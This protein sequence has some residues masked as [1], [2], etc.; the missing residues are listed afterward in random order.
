M[1]KPEIRPSTT[2]IPWGVL[3]HGSIQCRLPI[4]VIW[5]NVTRAMPIKIAHY[6]PLNYKVKILRHWC[7]RDLYLVQ[8]N[9]FDITGSR[10]NIGWD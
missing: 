4:M 5:R 9:F 10:R 3:F 7:D 1:L 8:K 2:E 6:G